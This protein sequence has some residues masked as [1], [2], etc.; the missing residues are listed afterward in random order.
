[1]L[2]QNYAGPRV[3][4]EGDYPSGRARPMRK[5]QNVDAHICTHIQAR[6]A[7]LDSLAKKGRYCR[8]VV[9][10]EPLAVMRVDAVSHSIDRPGNPASVAIPVQQRF[11]SRTQAAD[12]TRLASNQSRSVAR[13]CLQQVHSE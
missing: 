9:L 7:R 6:R 11:V 5:L 8:V 1:M 4:F 12:Q 10:P 3:G 13:S 2:F